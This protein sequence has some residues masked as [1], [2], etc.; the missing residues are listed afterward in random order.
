M[1]FIVFID[2]VVQFFCLKL[3]EKASVIEV[4]RCIPNS[5]RKPQLFI[6]KIWQ[7]DITNLYYKLIFQYEFKNLAL[8]MHSSASL[9]EYDYF[10]KSLKNE[11]KIALGKQ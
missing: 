5:K 3:W 2:S 1:Y 6:I 11:Q 7:A 8:I 9:H 4:C 10:W